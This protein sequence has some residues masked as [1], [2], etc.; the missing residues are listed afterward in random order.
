MQQ[1]TNT[2]SIIYASINSVGVSQRWRI[3]P[4]IQSDKILFVFKALVV[5][6]AELRIYDYQTKRS[7]FECILCQSNTNDYGPLMVFNFIFLSMVLK[8][9]T[10]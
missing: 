6:S 5:K 2:S 10:I 1:L 7:L 9:I 3:K 8:L 4:N